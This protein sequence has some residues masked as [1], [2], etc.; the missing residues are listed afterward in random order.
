MD[1]LKLMETYVAVVKN[2]S[3][4]R[5]ARELGVT[6]AMVSKRVQDLEDVLDTKLLHRNTHGLSTTSIG[7]DYFDSATG[8]LAQLNDIEE[9]V[10]AKRATPRGDL[11]VLSSKT[12]GETILGPI[13]AE[14]CNLYPTISVQVTLA[15]RETG[16]GTHGI[17]LV[18]GGFDIAVRTLPARDSALIGKAITGLPRI[19]VAAPAYLERH[20]MPARP[21]DLARHNCLD[22]SGKA[23]YSWD[24]RGKNGARTQ[25]V[26][27]SGAPRANSS[28]VIRDAALAGLGIAILRKYLILDDIAGGALVPVLADHV[29]DERTLYVIYQ[30]DRRLPLRMKVFIEYL[31][32]RVRDYLAGGPNDLPISNPLIKRTLRVTEHA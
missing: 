2:G 10:Q 23:Q 6:R 14:F 28:F 9:R 30:K 13:I 17:D 1:R 19:L 15:D 26:R 5:A 20:G 8:L 11:K 25:I 18:S 16:A 31:S 29:I 3:Y 27:V 32:K 7:Q 22:P 12:F 24:F 4:T 21:E